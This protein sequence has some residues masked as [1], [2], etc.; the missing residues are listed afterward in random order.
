MMSLLF[1]LQI[2]YTTKKLLMSN[3]IAT[4]LSSLFRIYNDN[5]RNSFINFINIDEI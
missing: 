4:E 3:L 2:H 5:T 1:N